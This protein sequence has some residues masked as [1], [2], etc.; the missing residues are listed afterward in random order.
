M[1]RLLL[2]LHVSVAAVDVIPEYH[3]L[4]DRVSSPVDSDEGCRQWLYEFAK[5]NPSHCTESITVSPPNNV[6]MS[7]D[8]YPYKTYA[9]T[10]KLT[11][12]RYQCEVVRDWNGCNH[13][14]L[15]S[16][17]D[18]SF[19]ILCE[20]IDGVEAQLKILGNFRR[21]EYRAIM[22]CERQENHQEILAL[23]QAVVDEARDRIR[24]HLGPDILSCIDSYL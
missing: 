11:D 18:I 8:A 21:N 7:T 4:R 10:R 15:W 3:Q 12:G 23:R 20:P 17:S 1:I 14:L 6:T 9:G 5:L 22:Y 2:V 16:F 13:R 24:Q 19:Y